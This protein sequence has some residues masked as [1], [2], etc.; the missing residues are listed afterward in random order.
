M[1]HVKEIINKRREYSS[2][3]QNDIIKNEVHAEQ[4]NKE[5]ENIKN[6]IQHIESL[7]QQPQWTGLIPMGKRIYMKGSIVHTG[8][9]LIEKQGYPSNYSYLATK[10]Q[11]VESLKNTLKDLEHEETQFNEMIKQLNERMSLLNTNTSIESENNLD[12]PEEIIA[13]KGVAIKVGDFYEIIE[14]EN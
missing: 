1:E 2:H 5:I 9:Y 8:E 7:S 6:T 12:L 11:A 13:D 4:V 14:Y 10:V 3:L